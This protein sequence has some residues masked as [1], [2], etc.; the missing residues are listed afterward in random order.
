MDIIFLHNIALYT[1]IGCYNWEQQ[2]QSKLRL[3]LDIAL[4]K[5]QALTDELEQTIDYEILL[6]KLQNALLTK[7][8][9]LIET[10]AEYI[11][12]IILEEFKAPWT[13]VAITKLGVLPE[14]GQ[15]GISI[16]RGKKVG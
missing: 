7:R 14:R 4:P 3:D 15:V 16:E 5:N 2:K 11:A 10:L 6:K 13:K 8:F 12:K 9:A 1:F